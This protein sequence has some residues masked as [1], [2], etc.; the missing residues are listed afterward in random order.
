MTTAELN[1]LD[2]LYLHMDKEGGPSTVRFVLELPAPGGPGRGLA[3]VVRGGAA[4]PGARARMADWQVTDSRYHW[5]I[6]DE[7]E[8]APLDVADC[9]DSAQVEAARER[10]LS[11]A[12][13]LD[14]ALRSR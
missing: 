9:E 10:A 7:L 13:P 6:A 2:Q 5:E 14:T 1:V 3:A 4:P 8:Q 12:P 11:T